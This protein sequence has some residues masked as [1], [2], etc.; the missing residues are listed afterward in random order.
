MHPDAHRGQVP[1]CE[2][3]AKKPMEREENRDP[4][5]RGLQGASPAHRAATRT[6]NLRSK[7]R[8]SGQRASKST[9]QSPAMFQVTVPS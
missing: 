9:D 5:R 3:G 8:P 6:G 4:Q 2:I 7:R 1:R